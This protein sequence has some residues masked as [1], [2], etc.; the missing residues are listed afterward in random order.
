MRFIAEFYNETKKNFYPE[1][2]EA[3][4]LDEASQIAKEKETQDSI[5]FEVYRA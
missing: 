3:S 1:V 5:L 2:V 4:D